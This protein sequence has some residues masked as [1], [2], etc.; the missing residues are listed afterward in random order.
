A[1]RPRLRAHAGRRPVDDGLTT[2]LGERRVP[3]PAQSAARR[4]EGPRGRRA[5][6]RPARGRRAV[7]PPQRG[8]RK[9]RTMSSAINPV[10]QGTSPIATGPSSIASIGK[11]QFLKL[12]V[13]Q[14]KNQD[15]MSP[16]QPNE[17][18]AQL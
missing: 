4:A 3:R 13:T 15:P 18:A 16:M 8:P 10:P 14:L 5:Q 7:A 11:D 9:E 6:G 1:R 2:R 17:F 12:L